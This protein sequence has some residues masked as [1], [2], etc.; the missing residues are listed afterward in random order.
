MKGRGKIAMNLT[1]KTMKTRGGSNHYLGP[2]TVILP[3][4]IDGNHRVIILFSL[5]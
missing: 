3:Q 4:G 2:N 5:Q 1:S